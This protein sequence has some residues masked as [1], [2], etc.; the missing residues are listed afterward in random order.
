MRIFRN[1]Y[2][3]DIYWAIAAAVI[4][5][6]AAGLMSCSPER[7]I[8]RILK[9][10]PELVRTDTVWG[11]VNVVISPIKID[12]SIRLDHDYSKV[13]SIVDGYRNKL[14]SLTR[15]KLTQEIK[16]YV[17]NK[18][19]LKDTV[20]FTQDGV[21]VKIWEQGGVLRWQLDKPGETKQVIVPVTVNKTEVKQFRSLKQRIADWLLDNFWFFAFFGLLILVALMFVLRS[22][23]ILNFPQKQ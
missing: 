10:N 11:K 13:D 4:I 2:L 16:Y 14:D 17:T 5:F 22:K 9:H 8:S 6:I 15:I 18:T 7:R 12:T 3:N 19:V 20:Q 23:K 1:I 21:K